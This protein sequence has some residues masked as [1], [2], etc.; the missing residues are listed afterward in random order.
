MTAPHGLLLPPQEGVRGHA[1]ASRPGRRAGRFK[2]WKPVV[3][4]APAMSWLDRSK[5]MSRARCPALMILD[6]G[7]GYAPSPG[8]RQPRP[9]GLRPAPAAATVRDGCRG[10]LDCEEDRWRRSPTEIPS[11]APGLV[12]R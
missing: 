6:V 1:V 7:V 5:V 4:M 3:A 10:R 9:V 11:R 2:S 12:G 8:S